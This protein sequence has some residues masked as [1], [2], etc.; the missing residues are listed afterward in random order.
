MIFIRY[1][2]TV[3]GIEATARDDY[4]WPDDVGVRYQYGIGN[5]GC[6]DNRSIFLRTA[7]GGVYDEELDC[8]ANGPN[9]IVI[10]WI[11]DA[12]GRLIYADAERDAVGK[13]WWDWHS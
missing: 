2:D 4:P 12:D 13:Q 7:S 1:R 8:N 10:D 11:K 6:D 5:Y 9:R 3:T